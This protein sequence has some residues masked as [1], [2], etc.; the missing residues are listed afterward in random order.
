MTCLSLNAVQFSSYDVVV[1]GGGAGGCAAAA[2]FSSKLGKGKVAVIDPAEVA[3]NTYFNFYQA[4]WIQ[5][6]PLF[7]VVS[8]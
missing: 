6:L 5:L 1:V 3:R 8:M 4:I 2:K 7:A